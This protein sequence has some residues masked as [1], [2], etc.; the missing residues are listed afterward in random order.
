LRQRAVLGP[1]VRFRRTPLKARM[2]ALRIITPRLS[3]EE[4]HGFLPGLAHGALL[5]EHAQARSGRAKGL[6]PPG[7]PLPLAAIGNRLSP[8]LVDH[9]VPW[10]R[11][12]KHGRKCRVLKKCVAE[13]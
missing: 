2:T 11:R 9:P 3:H 6:R 5:S 1:R 13:K 12:G 4:W 10:E 7:T 8:M